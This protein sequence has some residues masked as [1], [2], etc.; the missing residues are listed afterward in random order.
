MGFKWC[1][2][3]LQVA[4]KTCE[5]YA[6]VTQHNQLFNFVLGF[7]LLGKKKKKKTTMTKSNLGKKGFILL[8]LPIHQRGKSEWELQQGRN[9]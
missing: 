9:P 4:Q 8:T 7:L 5:F 3:Q 6:G 2:F 1:D